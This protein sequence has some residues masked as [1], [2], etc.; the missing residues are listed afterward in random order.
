MKKAAEARKRADEF[1]AFME[2]EVLELRSNQEAIESLKKK[3]AT[4]EKEALEAEAKVA[5][6]AGAEAQAFS[7]SKE[8]QASWNLAELVL[9]GASKGVLRSMFKE[10]LDGGLP[11]GP[12]KAPV[13]LAWITCGLG[14]MGVLKEAAKAPKEIL[15]V[16][17]VT[18]P[19]M[20]EGVS[21][22]RR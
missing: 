20:R 15:F 19:I 1:S 3:A 7:W 14:G 12:V 21:V 2:K 22:R 9:D 10:G 5:E 6:L 8:E 17:A 16:D 11:A 18:T 13:W 4:S